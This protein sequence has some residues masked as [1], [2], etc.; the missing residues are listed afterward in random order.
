MPPI[1]EFITQNFK[2][3]TVIVSFVVTMYVQHLN[4]TSHILELK[5]KCSTLELKTQDQYEKIDAI[6]LDKTVFEATITQFS[7]ISTD[8]REIRADIKELLKTHP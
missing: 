3:L 5:E 4:N 2:T 6:K 7:A 8:I 1:K